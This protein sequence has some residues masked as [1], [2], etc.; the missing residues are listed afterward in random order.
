M[1]ATTKPCEPASTREV[2]FFFTET[3]DGKSTCSGQNVLTTIT[4]IKKNAYVLLTQS[5]HDILGTGSL[6]DFVHFHE[7]GQYSM[8]DNCIATSNIS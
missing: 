8:R 4:T 2:I 7:T 1:L 3:R 5:L 6:K